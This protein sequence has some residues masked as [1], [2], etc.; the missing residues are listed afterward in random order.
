M[1]VGFSHVEHRGL[2]VMA[3]AGGADDTR[4][5]KGVNAGGATERRHPVLAAGG[6]EG[7]ERLK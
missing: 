3:T 2:H 5:H 6:K 1:A 7:R 4:I